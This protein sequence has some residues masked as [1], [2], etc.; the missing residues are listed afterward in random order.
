MRGGAAKLQGCFGR[1]RFN[2]GNTA[3]AIRSE[4]FFL[5]HHGLIETLKER[6]VNGKLLAIIPTSKRH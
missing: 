6:F 1:N 4:N 3:D 2:V 5:L